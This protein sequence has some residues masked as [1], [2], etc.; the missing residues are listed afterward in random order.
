M[1]IPER[2]A[3]FERWR[4]SFVE[5][6]ICRR[7]LDA[8]LAHIDA[9]VMLREAYA[10][11][12]WWA[13]MPLVGWPGE[14]LAGL[15]C[16][17]E[18]AFFHYGGGTTVSTR[19]A[20]LEAQGDS[21]VAA[22]AERVRERH[23]IR[24]DPD[25]YTAQELAAIESGAAT[26]TW[27]GGHMVLDFERVLDIGLDGYARDIE[28]YRGLHP[29]K[30]DF[31]E[32]L[33]ILLRAIQGLILRYADAAAGEGMAAR[34][35]HIAHG[36]PRTF[37]EA[38]Q[39]VW[40]L[41]ALNNA[42]SYGRLDWYLHPFY[43]ADVAAGRLTPG[44]AAALVGELCLKNEAAQQIQNMTLG[45]VDAQGRDFYPPLTKI[46]I[47]VTREVGYKGPNLCLRVTPTMPR[48]IWDAALD[49]IATGI[50]LPALYN[51]GV[52][53]NA[54]ARR[55]VPIEAA[56]GYCLAGCSQVMLPGMCNFYNDIGLFNAAKAAELA[57]YGGLDPRTGKQAGPATKPAVDCADFEELMDAFWAQLD[58]FIGM[59]TAIHNRELAYRRAREGYV[60]R[61]L[62]TRDCLETGR[63]VFG[64]GARYNN[65]EL[66]LIGITNAA[67]HLFAVK[68][69]VFEERACTMAEL[70][71]ALRNDWAGH[72]DLRRYCLERVPKFGND[73]P[74]ADM[75]RGEI[76]R[77]L[78]R[79]FNGTP[80]ALG[81]VFVPGEAI[82][83]THASC[84]AVAGATAD[85]RRAYSVL[86]D[87]AGASQGRDRC[88]P[89]ALMNSVL[90]SPANEYLLTTAV[91]N[92]KFLPSTFGGARDKVRDLF[93]TFFA[94]G[95]MQLQVNV[96]DA[97][98]LRKAQQNPEAYQ[99]LVVRVGG[100]SDYFTALSRKLQDEI[101]LRTSHALGA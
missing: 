17:N 93:R 87:S 57:M 28:H 44:R 2:K 86:A 58:Y 62:F 88:G 53:V 51:D 61:T 5:P 91:T 59:E 49:S 63:N 8:Y 43:E 18:A 60:M 26:S 12:A 94:Q 96:C 101:I 79:R 70:V 83:V 82:F 68:R 92:I 14:E 97:E 78:Y 54:L 37:H 40:I 50:G 89:T 75:L 1:T 9:P 46:I 11:Q 77:H 3:N 27:F 71:E 6:A 73:D 32:A 21:T 41:H 24:G 36:R 31:Y 80:S 19:A 85:G 98:T 100:Y 67:D 30:E 34:L 13:G 95:G 64:G 33:T 22:D 35:R 47:D 25:V 48:E 7:Y 81:G 72:E 39:L 65:I 16:Y 66:E 42:D 4:A 38:L 90:N 23:Y 76:A 52:Y 74:A 29:G 20:K 69:A 15:L 55:G 84:G 10:V 56:R 45:G 99:G